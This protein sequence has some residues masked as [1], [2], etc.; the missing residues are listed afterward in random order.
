MGS[1]ASTGLDASGRGGGGGPELSGPALPLSL[2][3]CGHRMM[4][5]R[6]P[7]GLY[8]RV[9]CVPF[10]PTD[11]YC[12]CLLCG[13]AALVQK[14]KKCV[15]ILLFLLHNVIPGACSPTLGLLYLQSHPSCRRLKAQHNNTRA[16]GSARKHPDGRE[17]AAQQSSST[18][19]TF[20]E[21]PRCTSCQTLERSSAWVTRDP[22][23]AWEAHS[24]QELGR[25]LLRRKENHLAAF[26]PSC[27]PELFHPLQ[28]V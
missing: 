25:C 3:I 8:P 15:F 11:V 5:Q 16:I 28:R 19:V 18:E 7:R 20:K 23:R 2:L 22:H 17:S 4:A 14:Q 21:N 10:N 24:L 9:Q 6:S 26:L 13:R 12:V 27:G 1:S